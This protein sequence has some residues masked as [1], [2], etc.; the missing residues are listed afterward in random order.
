M[1]WQ[2]RQVSIS[3]SIPALPDPTLDQSRRDRRPG[4]RG[5]H[6]M[7]HDRVRSGFCEPIHVIPFGDDTI[8]VLARLHDA[9]SAQARPVVFKVLVRVEKLLVAPLFHSKTHGTILRLAEIL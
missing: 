6:G 9:G 7:S 8:V 1:L 4:P 2:H 5:C 3:I